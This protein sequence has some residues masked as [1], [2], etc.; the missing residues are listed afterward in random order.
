M[1]Y[2]SLEEKIVKHGNAVDFLRND[3]VGANPFPW[4]RQ[5]TNWR[6]EQ[7]AWKDTAVL[8]DQSFHMWSHYFEGPD[9][10]RLFTDISVSS[11]AKFGRNRAKQLIV[12][13]YDGYFIGDAVIF[14]LEDDK[15]LVTGPPTAANWAQ[16][17]AETAG[18]DIR[19]TRDEQK[20]HNAGKR[21][22]YR[23]QVQGPNAGKIVEKAHGKPLEPIGF[24]RMG[25]FTIAG[26]NVRGLNHTMSGGRGF[27]M[28]GL[29]LFGPLDDGPVVKDALVAAGEEFGLRLG[30]SI[31]YSTVTVESGWI[32]IPVP[33]VYTGDSMLPYR[34]W[35]PGD[36]WEARLS[37]GGSFVSD[38]IEDYYVRPSDLGY[39]HLVKFDHDFIGREA[40]QKAHSGRQRKK[41]WLRWNDEDVTAAIA[42]SLFGSEPRTKSLELPRLDYAY[43]Q[44][45]MVLDK[46]NVVGRSTVAAYTVNVGSVSS[47]AMV[48][49]DVAQD[50][51][52]VTVVWGEPNGGSGKLLVEPHV[53]TT[54]R[55]T[56][57]TTRL[58]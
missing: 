58:V 21:T 31:A 9:L 13:N 43:S 28:N 46:D 38:K 36:G 37:I 25:E 6:D 45:D 33:A 17:H 12:C 32:P 48:D 52:E 15:W 18:Y 35:L 19:V 26:K 1:A 51:K 8:F 42:R 3:P 22:L 34:E 20:Q 30:G 27:E 55:A 23:F 41:V 44:N 50:G 49:E 29:E 14:G 4:Q 47:L 57:S 10:K 2:S 16:F 11:F 7:R 53:Q 40:L 39:G 5:Y 54:I 24:F 56:V